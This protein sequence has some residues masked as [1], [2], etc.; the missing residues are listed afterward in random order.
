M[1]RPLQRLT[2][3]LLLTSEPKNKASKAKPTN[4]YPAITLPRD[5]TF[6]GS[7]A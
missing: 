1:R 7:L 3:C 5:P 2:D 6:F 4:S